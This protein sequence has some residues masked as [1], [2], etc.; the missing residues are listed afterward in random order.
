MASITATA[1]R[2]KWGARTARRRG[3]RCRARSR[4]AARDGSSVQALRASY[5]YQTKETVAPEENWSVQEHGAA[6]VP[7]VEAIEPI[8]A[9]DRAKRAGNAAF[10]AGE[11]EAAARAY[12]QAI[13]TRPSA[14]VRTASTTI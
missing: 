10:N 6:P 9:A 11:M 14:R 4:A 2:G 12:T 13:A 1:T 5:A 3:T 8:D 7:R